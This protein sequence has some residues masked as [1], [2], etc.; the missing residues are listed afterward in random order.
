M[1]T[2][3]DKT[4]TEATGQ[5]SIFDLLQ[6]RYRADG[7]CVSELNF[8]FRMYSW[9]LRFLLLEVYQLGIYGHS[10]DYSFVL[11][12]FTN[13]AIFQNIFILYICIDFNKKKSC[14]KLCLC[15]SC[16][17][18]SGSF[19]RLY[20]IKQVKVLYICFLYCSHSNETVFKVY[21]SGRLS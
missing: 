16:N 4:I 8:V 9:Q 1:C 2:I 10:M 18:F 12:A 19:K 3:R 21:Y 6:M 20:F 11:H 17:T 13:Q 15:M 7:L 5:Y 14:L